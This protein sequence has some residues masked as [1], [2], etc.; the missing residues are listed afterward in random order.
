[1]STKQ[2][3]SHIQI[4][5]DEKTKKQAKKTLEELGL[6]VSSAVKLFLRNVIITESIPFDIKTKNGFTRQQETQMLKEADEA[7][8]KGKRYRSY[9]KML[10][11]IAK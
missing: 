3:Q 7:L 8:K 9:K 2:A 6:D 4:R 5:I 1:M 10:K 11:D